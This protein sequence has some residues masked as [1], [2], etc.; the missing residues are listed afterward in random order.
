MPDS[1]LTNGD[2]EII[3]SNIPYYPQCRTDGNIYNA[4]SKRILP[5]RSMGHFGQN[6]RDDEMWALLV[7]CWNREPSARPTVYKLLVW[8]CY[9]EILRCI[10]LIIS[11][12]VLS[13][14]I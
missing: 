2:Q 5:E 3:T 10:I 8:V 6:K 14:K 1:S 7:R 9:L 13:C 4:L 11:A 12:H